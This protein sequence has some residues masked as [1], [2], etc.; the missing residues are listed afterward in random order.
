MR[1]PCLFGVSRELR[2]SASLCSENSVGKIG[3]G[4]PEGLPLSASPRCTKSGWAVSEV[5][6]KALSPDD[7][8]PF[9]AIHVVQKI[10]S[11]SSQEFFLTWGLGPRLNS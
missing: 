1:N 7:G 8:R 11:C 5:E 6:A 3:D 9:W 10:G 4:W 2:L